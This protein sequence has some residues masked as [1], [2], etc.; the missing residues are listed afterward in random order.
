VGSDRFSTEDRLASHEDAAPS[1]LASL[2]PATRV[3][4]I[5]MLLYRKRT[6]KSILFRNV[7]PPTRLGEQIGAF[8]GLLGQD[9]D[10]IGA[11]FAICPDTAYGLM[12]NA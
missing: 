5:Y 3:S 7:I 2:Y 9:G 12:Y 6:L 1:A 4:R 10:G 11:V 8:S